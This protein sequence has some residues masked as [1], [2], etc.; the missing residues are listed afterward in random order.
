MKIT[1]QER[2]GEYCLHR[3]QGRSLFLLLRAAIKMENM[4]EIDGEK[5]R[6]FSSDF[7][8]ESIGKL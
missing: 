3:S 2:F 4:L 8:E 6:I 1:L 5:I 7:L